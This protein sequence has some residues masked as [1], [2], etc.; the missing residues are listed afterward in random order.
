MLQSKLGWFVAFIAV[1]VV[2]L[3]CLA[4]S[5][6][7]RPS[8]PRV[9]PTAHVHGRLL[10]NGEGMAGYHVILCHTP[11][12]GIPPQVDTSSDGTFDLGTVPSGT[13]WFQVDTKGRTD[14][15]TG[16]ERFEIAQ[17]EDREVEISRDAGFLRGKLIGA[18]DDP[19]SLRVWASPGKKN[20]RHATPDQDG[21]FE[22]GPMLV[23]EYTLEVKRS[24]DWRGV[25]EYVS[26]DATSVVV[27]KGVT[28]TVA[29][30]EV[31]REVAVSGRFE[32][33]AN[34]RLVKLIVRSGIWFHRN[35]GNTMT[36]VTAHVAADGSFA[37]KLVA[38]TYSFGSLG[39]DDDPR[40][41]FGTLGEGEINPGVIEKLFASDLAF[42]QDLYRRV[43]QEGHTRAAVCCPSCGD[44][45]EVDVT[46]D[47]LGGS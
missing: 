34:P 14:V 41:E 35:H 40:I 24:L 15:F 20:S 29:P 37:V 23:G 47:G 13:S 18:L 12:V 30:I 21:N 26:G 28:T 39:V 25:G 9:Q 6:A 44:E 11:W 17:D 10:V 19:S 1:D 43:N 3:S 33:P 32:L 16:S 31:L 8:V 45:F 27:S 42:L 7:G 2:A 46:G 36:G 5:K 22:I 38:G 4:W